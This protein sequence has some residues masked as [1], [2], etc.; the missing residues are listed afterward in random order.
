MVITGY[1][2][3]YR[4]VR[5][6]ISPIFTLKMA[7]L[8]CRYRESRKEDF[9]IIEI[10]GSEN[11]WCLMAKDM[12]IKE[13]ER[14]GLVRVLVGPKIDDKSLVQI[15]NSGKYS[16]MTIFVPDE[17]LVRESEVNKK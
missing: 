6:I 17:F 1:E 14:E 16:D 11:R 3:L 7:Y 13:N 15:L 2:P 5:F 10:P 12:V 9:Y 4:R 8:R